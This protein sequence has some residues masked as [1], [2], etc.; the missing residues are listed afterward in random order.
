MAARGVPYPIL[1]YDRDSLKRLFELIRENDYRYILARYSQSTSG[2]FSLPAKFRRRTIVDIDD[3]LSGSVYNSLYNDKKGAHR[4]ILRALNKKLLARYEK[5]CL[6]F[7]AALFCSEPDR[8]KLD[9]M[10]RGN[11]FVVPNIYGN[12]LFESYDF[13][14]GYINP[15]T[16]LFVGTLHYPPN[17]EGLRWF[18]QTIF[19]RFKAEVPDAR[20]VVVGHAPANE[21]K[22]VCAG[23]EGVELHADVA[24]VREYYMK[25]RAAVVPLLAGG[26]T[27]IKILEA[28]L[29]NRPILSTPLGAEGLEMKDGSDLLFFETPEDF[30]K[31]Y[32]QLSDKK[33]YEAI[34]DRARLTVQ[35]KYS[36]EKF[37]KLMRL[38]LWHL[39]ESSSRAIVI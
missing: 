11:T 36:R 29:G 1:N 16:L 3:L 2:L 21:V 26:G 19:K 27:R 22:T 12:T 15:N 38:V 14:D 10:K 25:C 20:M 35:E 17:V 39:E 4:K 13:G 6:K 9:P 37:E 7:G 23:E 32:Q 8:V 31:K 28:A 30:C 5:R 24:D 18:I 34:V 33:T